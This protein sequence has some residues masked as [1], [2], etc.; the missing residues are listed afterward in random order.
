[1]T[2][3]EDAF[4]LYPGEKHADES[5][6]GD[7]N[8]ARVPDFYGTYN[9]RD[10]TE[11]YV[12]GGPYAQWLSAYHRPLKQNTGKCSLRLELATDYNA[13]TVAQ[14]IELDLKIAIG[15]WIY[16]FSSQINYRLGGMWQLTKGG[17]GWNDT[18]WKLGKFTPDLFYPVQFDYAFDV[19]KRTYSAKFARI[20]VKEFS[21]PLAQQ[22]QPAFDSAVPNPAKKWKDGASVQVQ[23]DLNALGGGFSIYARNAKLV[24]S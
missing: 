2:P 23:I 12:K 16:D 13:V 21:V 11:F 17:Q 15:G 10:A 1:M 3:I 20:G 24:W 19:A 5:I 7:P 18:G 4:S 9:L 6:S 8:N 14:A 22:N